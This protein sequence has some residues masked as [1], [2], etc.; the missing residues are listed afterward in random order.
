MVVV[1]VVIVVSVVVVVVVAVVA[2]LIHTDAGRKTR[3]LQ[4]R[5]RA[6]LEEHGGLGGQ[7]CQCAESHG[8]GVFPKGAS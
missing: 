4:N 5:S 6:P 2:G 7:C 3:P 1:I 8:N